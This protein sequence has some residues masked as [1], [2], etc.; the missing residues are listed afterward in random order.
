MLKFL[1]HHVTSRLKNVQFADV[2]I[3]FAFNTVR[4]PHMFVRDI[5]C[6]RASHVCERY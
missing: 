5:C 4:A 1:V 2:R 3:R 6:A